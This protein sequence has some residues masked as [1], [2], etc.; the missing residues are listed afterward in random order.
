MILYGTRNDVKEVSKLKRDVKCYK[1][2]SQP[3]T[4][5]SKVELN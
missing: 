2:Y 4:T 5:F 3:I 1:N